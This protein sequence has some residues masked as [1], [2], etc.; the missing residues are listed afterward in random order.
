MFLD[1]LT[2]TQ[3]FIT[4][5]LLPVLPGLT[6]FASGHLHNNKAAFIA[7]LVLGLCLV[8]IIL[9]LSERHHMLEFRASVKWGPRWRVFMSLI[10][11]SLFTAMCTLAWFAGKFLPPNPGA[12]GTC[13]AFAIIIWVAY[14][15]WNFW[16]MRT[17]DR[18][19][20]PPITP[21]PL[22]QTS[23]GRGFTQEP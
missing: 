23:F 11:F 10:S 3:W 13:F 14:E 19:F 17:A 8:L 2:N 22:H 18:L 15:G 20:S 5:C 12:G 4:T 16:L 1:E 9:Y 21:F 7:L 6:M